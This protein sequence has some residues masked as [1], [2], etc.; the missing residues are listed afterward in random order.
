MAMPIR[1]G[2]RV[3]FLI[4]WGHCAVSTEDRCDSTT[5]GPFREAKD[6]RSKQTGERL[7][8]CWET[9][10]VCVCPEKGAGQT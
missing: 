7:D 3:A 6:S 2:L 1:R 4:R 9:S 10:D 5:G 8:A